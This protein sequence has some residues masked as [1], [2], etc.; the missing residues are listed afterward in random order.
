M[1]CAQRIHQRAK[2]VSQLYLIVDSTQ[3]VRNKEVTVIILQP[4]ECNEEREPVSVEH[5]CFQFR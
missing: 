1:I 4:V 5:L 2:Q 3:D